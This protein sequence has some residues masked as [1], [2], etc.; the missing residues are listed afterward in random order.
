MPKKSVGFILLVCLALAFCA[1]LNVCASVT[2]DGTEIRV[3]SGDVSE[4]E[5]F[6]VTQ[7]SVVS[8]HEV[9]DLTFSPA[10][11]EMSARRDW[12]FRD[13]AVS[14][15]EPEIRAALV[16]FDYEEG[17][18]T[19]LEYE[20]T[21]PLPFAQE[22]LDEA[23]DKAESW[24]DSVIVA[25]RLGDY[26]D[27]VP[28]TFAARGLGE[29]AG[30]YAD[31]LDSQRLRTAY[32]FHD[33]D[34]YDGMLLSGGF[35]LAL[36]EILSV[37]GRLNLSAARNRFSVGTDAGFSSKYSVD[38]SCVY[39][40]D[41][42][43]VVLDV[44]DTEYKS[45]HYNEQGEV[46][47]YSMKTVLDSHPD[48]E[49]LPGDSWGIYRIPCDQAADGPVPDFTRVENIYPITRNWDDIHLELSDD[50]DELLLFTGEADGE[51]FTVVDRETGAEK[52]RFKIRDESFNGSTVD[53][54]VGVDSV[55]FGSG[56]NFVGLVRD[57]G[58]WRIEFS[59]FGRNE[60]FPDHVVNYYG[61]ACA[62]DGEHLAVL[63]WGWLGKELRLRILS[64]SGVTEE[65]ILDSSAAGAGYLESVYGLRVDA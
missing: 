56:F 53:C 34:G 41:A 13:T 35:G 57:D 48:P 8:G 26:M 46:S 32:P 30:V 59:T 47:S 44:C 7:H 24:E 9:V 15:P 4:F 43:Y 58:V 28:F 11:G 2:G 22:L 18:Y 27:T 40:G 37:S 14:E 6:T 63:D 21:I 23:Y 12:N 50:G 20:S 10:S 49:G 19:D 31:G 51:W 5:G 60:E 55:V 65:L 54:A 45:I 29:A 61:F 38:S 17:W 25:R 64:G 33:L 39:T 36:P 52:Q 3:V 16:G 62:W 1:G 42:F